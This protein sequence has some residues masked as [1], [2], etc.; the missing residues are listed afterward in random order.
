MDTLLDY[1][2]YYASL[3][4]WVFPVR[5][6]PSKPFINKKGKL[7]ILKEKTPYIKGG[8]KSAS[9]NLDQIKEWWEQWSQAAIGVSCK[10]SNLF[11][12]DVDV[13]H[14]HNG[15]DNFMQLGIDGTGALNSRTPSNGLHWVFS[16]IGKTTT[17]ILDGIDT[18]GIGGYFIAPPS[19]I[20]EGE[21]PGNY[22]AIE[23]WNKRPIEIPE[24]VL[25]KLQACKVKPEKRHEYISILPELSQDE[26]IRRAREALEKL[27]IRMC[28][29]YQDWIEIGLSLYQLSDAGL[30]LWDQWSRKSDKYVPGECEAKWETFSPNLITLGSLF[31]YSKEKY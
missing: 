8:F 4:F 2:L 20:I 18:R 25:E 6:K 1:A 10:H 23:P 31:Y 26:N 21:H 14:G 16:G 5:E 24:Y 17:N 19:K 7:T 30:S 12:I 29:N 28:E 15:F 22:I 11:V 27:P 9:I 13:K 3:N